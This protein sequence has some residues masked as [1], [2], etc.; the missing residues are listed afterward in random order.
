MRLSIEIFSRQRAY[1]IAPGD[2]LRR[3]P[4]DRMYHPDLS[5]DRTQNARRV[6]IAM[7]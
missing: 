5:E 2:G 1:S 6:G 3:D 7:R 4:V